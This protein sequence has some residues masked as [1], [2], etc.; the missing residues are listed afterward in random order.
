MTDHDA[1]KDGTGATGQK[2]WTKKKIWRF[3]NSAFVIWVLGT[4]VVGGIGG[5]FALWKRHHDE[6]KANAQAVVGL[7]K[8]IDQRLLDILHLL[9]EAEQDS[10]TLKVIEFRLRGLRRGTLLKTAKGEVVRPDDPVA[11]KAYKAEE[12]IQEEIRARFRA[13]PDAY[14]LLEAPPPPGRFGALDPTSYKDSSVHAL[15]DKLAGLVDA[16]D[17]AEITRVAGGI[18]N[19]GHAQGAIA[20][21]L[22]RKHVVL[23]RWPSSFQRLRRCPETDPLCLGPM[24][25]LRPP[26]L[27]IYDETADTISFPPPPPGGS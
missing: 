14:E 22:L 15:L 5:L 1:P 4:V 13:I 8:E 24:P 12:R 25:P 10:R 16:N 11:A 23:S 2:R 20:A 18:G 27:A 9:Q 21:E 17:R 3:L 6:K 19:L 7:D 26:P